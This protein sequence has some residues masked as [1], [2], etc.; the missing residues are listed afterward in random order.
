[1]KSAA[2][3]MLCRFLIASMFAMSLQ[4]AMAGV[5]GTEQAIAATSAQAERAALIA[6][7]SR[8]DVASQ[9][10]V[11][12]DG[13]PRTFHHRRQMGVGVDDRVRE[14]VGRLRHAPRLGCDHRLSLA[15]RCDHAAQQCGYTSSL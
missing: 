15:E 9:L 10:Q 1:M 11:R 2:F 12:L 3:R 8:S 4:P 13:H 6:T 14:R 5:I 7:L